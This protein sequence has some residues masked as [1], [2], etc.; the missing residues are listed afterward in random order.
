MSGASLGGGFNESDRLLLSVAGPFMVIWLIMAG[1]R[2][3]K[4]DAV[5]A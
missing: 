5:Q 4:S 2:L 1:V 3:S